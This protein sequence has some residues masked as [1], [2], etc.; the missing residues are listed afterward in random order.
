[1]T[2]IHTS[3][4]NLSHTK[5]LIT[6]NGK[7]KLIQPIPN[8]FTAS[9][10]SHWVT[11]SM[12]GAWAFK[13]P[14]HSSCPTQVENAHFR[15]AYEQ[16]DVFT[17]WQHHAEKPG[18]DFSHLPTKEIGGCHWASAAPAVEPRGPGPSVLLA[19]WKRIWQNPIGTGLT[20]LPY[21]DL[22]NTPWPPL[23][24]RNALQ[25]RDKITP[26]VCSSFQ[27]AQGTG[28]EGWDHRPFSCRHHLND[29]SK[30][31]QADAWATEP[32][33]ALPSCPDIQ[34]TTPSDSH[35]WEE[36]NLAKAWWT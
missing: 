20:H 9:T 12:Q 23:T 21:A 1:M 5:L 34:K 16:C 30:R 33:S 25:L 24:A 28:W 4:M 35:P 14:V 8:L 26:M 19:T 2:K 10:T 3:S 36:L 18:A 22:C 11:T 6:N 29:S 13:F 31:C 32:G 27:G 17:K 7:K 15:A